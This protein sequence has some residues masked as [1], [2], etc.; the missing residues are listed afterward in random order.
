MTPVLVRPPERDMTPVSHLTF[1]NVTTVNVIM[2]DLNDLEQSPIL[3]SCSY[4]CIIVLIL[5]VYFL[6]RVIF[7]AREKVSLLQKGKGSAVFVKCH[8]KSLKKSGW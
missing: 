3:N 7:C 5:I 4:C 6:P 2:K 8:D 1:R